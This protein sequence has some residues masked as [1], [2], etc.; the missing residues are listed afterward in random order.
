MDGNMV[1]PA[2]KCKM[3]TDHSTDRNTCTVSVKTQLQIV[4]SLLRNWNMS[5]SYKEKPRKIGVQKWKQSTEEKE[6]KSE[7][8]AGIPDYLQKY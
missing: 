4:L 2:H 6:D 1:K 3:R 7:T 5:A 8:C